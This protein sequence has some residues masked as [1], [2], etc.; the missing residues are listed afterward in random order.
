MAIRAT[1]IGLVFGYGLDYYRDILR[2]I[3]AFAEARPRWVFTPIA[4]ESK[5]VR[6][7]GRSAITG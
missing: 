6:A 2:G 1:R 4:P 7:M 3:K 5:A